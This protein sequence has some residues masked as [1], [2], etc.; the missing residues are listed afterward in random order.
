MKT[1]KIYFITAFVLTLQ[2][3]L[4]AQ[5]ESPEEKADRI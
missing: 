3:G 4:I 2:P 5:T 1:L